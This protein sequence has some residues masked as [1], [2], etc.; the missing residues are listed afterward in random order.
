MYIYIPS[1]YNV[2]SSVSVGSSAYMYSSISE[3]IRDELNGCG[4]VVMINPIHRLPRL[5]IGERPL[6]IMVSCE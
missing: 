3:A 6:Y 1:G 5:R 4:D 2:D